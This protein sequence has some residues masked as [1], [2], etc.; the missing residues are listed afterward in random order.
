[1]SLRGWL[2]SVIETILAMAGLSFAASYS[3][4]AG[5]PFVLALMALAYADGRLGWS[6][7]E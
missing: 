7:D 2:L 3:P 1:M 5:L 6:V 4:W